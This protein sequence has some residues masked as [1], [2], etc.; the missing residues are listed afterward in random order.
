L[1]IIPFA[2]PLSLKAWSFFHWPMLLVDRPYASWLP[3]NAGKRVITLLVINVA[4]WAF[5]LFALRTAAR[6][7]IRKE[8]SL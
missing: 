6:M 8:T 7:V 2:L 5:S 1:T 3:L 4:G